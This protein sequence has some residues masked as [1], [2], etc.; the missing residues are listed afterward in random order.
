MCVCVYV[1]MYVCHDRACV[2]VCVFHS[3]VCP[4]GAMC[5]DENPFTCQ[6]KKEDKK[7]LRVSNLAL[8]LVISK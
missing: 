4:E 2:C 7:Y 1:H 5:S 6:C 3:R 8:L